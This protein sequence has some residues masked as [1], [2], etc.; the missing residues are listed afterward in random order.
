M[1]HSMCVFASVCLDLCVCMFVCASVNIF[2]SLRDKFVVS[3]S[4][5]ILSQFSLFVSCAPPGDQFVVPASLH[6]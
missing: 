4:L 5:F 6:Y 3:S 2:V 1:M